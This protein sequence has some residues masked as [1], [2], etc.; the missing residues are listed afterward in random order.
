MF[1][2]ADH[3]EMDWVLRICF[4]TLKEFGI[5]PELGRKKWS[6][7]GPRLR[8][9]GRMERKKEPHLS[10]QTFEQVSMDPQTLEV[11][12]RPNLWRQAPKL[13]AGKT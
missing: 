2:R 10:G 3:A 8:F 1:S 9:R 4:C 7:C 5:S 13:V 12:E 6:F 11:L